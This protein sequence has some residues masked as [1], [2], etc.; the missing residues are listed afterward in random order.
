MTGV[1]DFGPQTTEPSTLDNQ[2]N[3]KTPTGESN[4][5]FDFRIG[6]GSRRDGRCARDGVRLRPL[7]AALVYAAPVAAA[8]VGLQPC[9]GVG[10]GPVTAVAP[11]DPEQQYYYVNQGPTYTGPRQLGAVSGLS[12]RRGLRLRLWLQPSVATAIARRY[13]HAGRHYGHARAAPLLLIQLGS[14]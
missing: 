14:V 13:G 12:R 5:S 2:A 4:A 1:P 7:R 8:T 9:G 3:K 6:R 11:A 10:C